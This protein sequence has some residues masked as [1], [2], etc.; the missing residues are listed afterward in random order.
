MTSLE[1]LITG[2]NSAI[3]LNERINTITNSLSR[4]YFGKILQK[5]A[6]NNTESAT[7]L[8]DYIQVEQT[9]FNIKDSTKEG[10]IKVLVWLSN[11][12]G[13][14]ISFKDMKKRDILD[15]LNN[16]RKSGNNDPT[17]K[18]IGSYN[19]RQMIL[20]K[21]FRWLYNPEEPDHRK[22]MTLFSIYA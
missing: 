3:G 18:W 21:F 22:R 16:L 19:G 13:D 8:C 6:Q 14:E 9:E 7:T 4:P 1:S 17:Q 11:Y 15:Y 12:F 20:N 2:I 5:L 10:K